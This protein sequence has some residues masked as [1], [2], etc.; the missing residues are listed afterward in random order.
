[1]AL[2][3]LIGCCRQRLHT[4]RLGFCVRNR[5]WV[6]CCQLG[7]ADGGQ[8]LLGKD[9]TSLQDKGILSCPGFPRVQFLVVVL[10]ALEFGVAPCLCGN[11][12]RLSGASSVSKSKPR[13]LAGIVRLV[14][15]PSSFSRGTALCAH[16]EPPHPK[17]EKASSST[18]LVAATVERGAVTGPPPAKDRSGHWKARAP[19]V[20]KM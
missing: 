19:D 10:S 2:L 17:K 9:A 4:S 1:M 20:T 16:V 14:T 7:V 3:R 18:R 6:P 13:A 5:S 11:L 12:P 15:R 8:L